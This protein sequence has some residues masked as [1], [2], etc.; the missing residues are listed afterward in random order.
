MTKPWERAER[1]IGVDGLVDRLAKAPG[2][3]LNTV[4]LEVMRRRARDRSI[5]A[6]MAQHAAGDFVNPCPVSPAHLDR[7]AALVR[8]VL[9]DRFEEVALAPVVPLGTVSAVALADQNK[10]CTAARS[11]EVLS[12]PT[13]ALALIAAER[14]RADPD[15]PVRLCA[16]HRALRTQRFDWPGATQHFELWGF[17]TGGRDP[18]GRAFEKRAL[19]EHIG[20]NLAILDA[21]RARGMPLGESRLVLFVDPIHASWVDAIDLPEHERRDLEPGYY[22]M[23]RIQ[24]DAERDGEWLNLADG[25][26]VDWLAQLTQSRR[27]R[28]FISGIGSE[29]LA[30]LWFS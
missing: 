11:T 7:I 3:A 15:Q 19:T 17:V 22:R 12:D 21:L 1:R 9:P 26:F 5:G 25:G 20:V 23:V 6:L 16:R 28:L 18:G 10:V 14:R 29:R 2:S 30:G 8:E 4:L 24:V 13:N 27:E